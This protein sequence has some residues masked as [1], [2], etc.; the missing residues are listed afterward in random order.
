MVG[1]VVIAIS[2]AAAITEQGLMALLLAGSGLVAVALGAT[3]H[4]VV[5]VR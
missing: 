1:L 3:R 4:D 5:A 2:I